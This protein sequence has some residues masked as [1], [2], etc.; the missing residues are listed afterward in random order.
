MTM[1][2]LAEGTLKTIVSTMKRNSSKKTGRVNLTREVLATKAGV[3]V[4]TVDRALEAL[5]KTRM[6]RTE[7]AKNYFVI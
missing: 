1:P 4:R 7:L 6:I 5:R 3:S 2:V